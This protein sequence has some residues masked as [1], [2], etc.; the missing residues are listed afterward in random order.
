MV[1]YHIFISHLNWMEYKNFITNFTHPGEKVGKCI[2][3]LH[4]R[5]TK[6]MEQILHI[7]GGRSVPK[8]FTFLF[9]ILIIRGKPYPRVVL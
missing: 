6:G 9:H 4:P 5:S 3:G 2:H 1:I 7:C 8:I